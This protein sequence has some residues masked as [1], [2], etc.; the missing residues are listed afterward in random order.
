MKYI[1]YFESVNSESVL[2]LL[3]SCGF[4]S[5]DELTEI[6]QESLLELK[7]F[8]QYYNDESDE[9][10][11]ELQ[12]FDTTEYYFNRYSKENKSN[13]KINDQIL[14][15]DMTNSKNFTLDRFLELI[16]KKFKFADSHFSSSNKKYIIINLIPE[17]LVY[18]EIYKYRSDENWE[19]SGDCYE[20]KPLYSIF[21][22]NSKES[23]R[24][25]QSLVGDFSIK[26]HHLRNMYDL[27]FS[28]S[29]DVISI[30]ILPK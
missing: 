7:D 2:E 23:L 20:I 30:R 16:N 10:F 15:I 18:Y 4:H 1:K 5:K 21:K 24:Y 26:L 3:K 17:N 9:D 14:S 29:G 8:I 28:Y 22:D 6:I 12:D 19:K 25:S 11:I 13:I 27:G